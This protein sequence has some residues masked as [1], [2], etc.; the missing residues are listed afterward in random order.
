MKPLTNEQKDD[1]FDN[2]VKSIAYLHEPAPGEFT[3]QMLENALIEGG[4]EITRAKILYRLDKLSDSGVLVKR[5]IASG[6]NKTNA[7][8]P[9]KDLS[10]EE[11]LEILLE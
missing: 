11:L 5:K 2:I 6:G 7:Y 10:Y 3:I 1:V 4:H 9:V 8:S